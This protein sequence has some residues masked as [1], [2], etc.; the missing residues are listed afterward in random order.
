MKTWGIY[1]REREYA[2]HHGDPLL[3]T[4]WAKD[5]EDA[6]TLAAQGLAAPTGVWAHPIIS[7]R[8]IVPAPDLERVFIYCGERNWRSSRDVR[9][10]LTPVPQGFQE[11]SSRFVGHRTLEGHLVAVWHLVHDSRFFFATTS[12]ICPP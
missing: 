10:V 3:T 1:H 9:W 11:S 6:E 2:R 4:V 7:S 8:G 5:K 12:W